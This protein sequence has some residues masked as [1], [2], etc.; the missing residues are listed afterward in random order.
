MQEDHFTTNISYYSHSL[1]YIPLPP[2]SLV[3]VRSILFLFLSYT[4]PP[5]RIDY[6]LQLRS[7][8]YFCF[9]FFLIFSFI[10]FWCK[11][12]HSNF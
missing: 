2:P 3:F 5:H 1:Y 7:M 11:I 6:S 12:I 10:L 9:L 4:C 8:V